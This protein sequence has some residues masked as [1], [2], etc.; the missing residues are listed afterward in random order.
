MLVVG[1][2]PSR[3]EP[4]GV[5]GRGVGTHF[6][7]ERLT[8]TDI[9]GLPHKNKWLSA[10]SLPVEA[11]HRALPMRIKIPSFHHYLASIKSPSIIEHL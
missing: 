10:Q 9:W 5:T 3:Q 2:I 11:T 1:L 7:R 8:V 4:E 6:L